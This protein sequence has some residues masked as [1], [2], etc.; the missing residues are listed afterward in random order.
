M[1]GISNR[2]THLYPQQNNSSVQ[3]TT[4]TY[5]RRSGQVTDG[6]QSGWRPLRHFVLSSPTP[7]PALLECLSQ[8]QHESRLTTFRTNV[9]RFRSCLYKWG[10][11]S[12]AACECGAE[13]QTVDRIVRQCPIHRC[14]S[15]N[16]CGCER[17]LPEFPQ[18]CSKTLRTNF[19]RIVS[20]TQI[21][22]T[23][24]G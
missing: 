4:T 20:L 8:E 11:A 18:I 12:S 2:E 24:L 9:G 3:L 10:M 14:R 13:E 1:D 7:T 17:F 21:M 5:V 6:M 15:R 23:L 22:K 16:F 19:V